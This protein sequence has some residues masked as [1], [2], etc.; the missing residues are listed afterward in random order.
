[1]VLPEF[2]EKA[3]VTILDVDAVQRF[4]QPPARYTEASLIQQLEE[5]GIGRP[6][7]YAPTIGTIVGRGYVSRENKRLYPTELGKMINDH[8]AVF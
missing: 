5:K 3:E 4:T 7:T 6:S 2:K 8:D 1:M